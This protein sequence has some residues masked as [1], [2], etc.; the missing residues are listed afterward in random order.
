MARY[1][2]TLRGGRDTIVSR[3]G[4][5]SSGLA[6]TADGWSIG[7]RIHIGPARNADGKDTDADEV[8]IELTGGSDGR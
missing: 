8:F 7:A 5:A 4:H 3:L 1:R 2:G 6:V